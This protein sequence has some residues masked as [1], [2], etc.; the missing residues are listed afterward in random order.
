MKLISF[1]FVIP[2]QYMHIH[3]ELFVRVHAEPDINYD[4]LFVCAGVPF[5]FKLNACLGCL[6]VCT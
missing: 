5:S 2:F 6:Y 4:Y 3:N 1:L